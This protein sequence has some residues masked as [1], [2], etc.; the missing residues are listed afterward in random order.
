MNYHKLLRKSR[1]TSVEVEVN[2]ITGDIRRQLL[3]E[4]NSVVGRSRM[5]SLLLILFLS[6]AVICNAGAEER[7]PLTGLEREEWVKRQIPCYTP[8]YIDLRLYEHKKA[9][10]CRI[11]N[12][13]IAPNTDKSEGK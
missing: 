8:G 5:K 7:K 2:G 4:Y 1:Y 11:G 10:N 6:A 3:R 9:N 13:Y 12:G